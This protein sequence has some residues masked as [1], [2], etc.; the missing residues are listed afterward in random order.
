VTLMC[1]FS[2]PKVDQPDPV[3]PPEYAQQRLP[4]GGQVRSNVM[5]RM[6]DRLRAAS[7]TILTSGSGVTTSAPTQAKTLLGA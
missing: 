6:R 2:A 7:S 5:S 1:M 3:M 4:D